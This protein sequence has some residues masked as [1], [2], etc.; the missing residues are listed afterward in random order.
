ML[1]KTS[2][3]KEYPA[4]WISPPIQDPTKLLMMIEDER[5]LVQILTEFD[6]LEW[7]ERV[8]NNQGDIRFSGYTLLE[9]IMRTER[10]VQITLA[11]E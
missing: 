10:G 8:S 2:R 7:L 9:G 4:K 11:K 3:N 5:P 1:I 6:G